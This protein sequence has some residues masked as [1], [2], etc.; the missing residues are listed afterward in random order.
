MKLQRATPHVSLLINTLI[1][2]AAAQGQT[3]ASPQTGKRTRL[4]TAGMR[5]RELTSPGAKCQLIILLLP[6][7]LLQADKLNRGS[8]NGIKSSASRWLVSTV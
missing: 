5:T 3:T 8:E 7:Q 2:K 4:R 1:A 6:S